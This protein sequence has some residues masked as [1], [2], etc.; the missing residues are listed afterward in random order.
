MQRQVGYAE[1]IVRG[2]Q[3]RPRAQALSKRRVG[4]GSAAGRR[5]H[6]LKFLLLLGERERRS[7][8]TADNRRWQRRLDKRAGRGTVG[9]C[10]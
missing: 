3:L 10:G 4:Q 1:P 6:G 7:T 2:G 9:A 8:A 5:Q